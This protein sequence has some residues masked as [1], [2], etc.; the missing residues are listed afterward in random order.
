MDWKEA[1]DLKI[2]KDQK[3][4]KKKRLRKICGVI[5]RVVLSLS[6]IYE[7][8]VLKHHKLF[9]CKHKNL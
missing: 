9:I 2:E 7:V 1:R 5:K 3:K 8:E 6:H 4:K